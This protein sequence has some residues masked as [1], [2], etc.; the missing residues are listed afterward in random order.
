MRVTQ[1]LA[2]LDADVLRRSPW[3]NIDGAT[4]S[5]RLIVFYQAVALVDVFIGLGTDDGMV[6]GLASA[7]LVLGIGAA[8]RLLHSRGN[9]PPGT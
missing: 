2:K 6:T 9:R 3:A 4:V 1:R 8:W 5:L 7:P